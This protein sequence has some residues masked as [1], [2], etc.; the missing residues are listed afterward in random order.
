MFSFQSKYFKNNKDGL[1]P[2][3]MNEQTLLKRQSE[4]SKK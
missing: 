4:I 1:D 3:S 2:I